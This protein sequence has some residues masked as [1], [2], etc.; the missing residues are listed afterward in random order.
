M[1][2]NKTA[3]IKKKSVITEGSL[4]SMKLRQTDSR[5]MGIMLSKSDGAEC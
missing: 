5:H 2:V 3:V 1:T 4:Y